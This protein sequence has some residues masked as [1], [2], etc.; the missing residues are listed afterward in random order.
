MDVASSRMAGILVAHGVTVFRGRALRPWAGRGS[1]HSGRKFM[2]DKYISLSYI[3]LSSFENTS[4]TAQIAPEIRQFKA[5]S[6]RY[7]WLLAKYSPSVDIN[8][9][10]QV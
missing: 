7:P 3:S 8:V 6:Y 4:V 9:S 10:L 1:A 2:G 5:E